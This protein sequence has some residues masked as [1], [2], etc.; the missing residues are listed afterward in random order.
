[1]M[2]TLRQLRV[3]ASR[4]LLPAENGRDTI[5][6]RLE[7]NLEVDEAARLHI[8]QGGV[9]VSAARHQ[10]RA[11][12][13]EQ[14][15]ALRVADAAQLGVATHGGALQQPGRHRVAEVRRGAIC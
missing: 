12:G 1:M 5:N 11:A 7:L 2:R 10:V 3:Y 13:V 4:P 8:E 14:G 9:A 6:L 15:D